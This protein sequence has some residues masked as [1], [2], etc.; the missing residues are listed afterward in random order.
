MFQYRGCAVLLVTAAASA[1]NAAETLLFPSVVRAAGLWAALALGAA[2]TLLYALFAVVYI[3]ETR[4]RSPED[5]YDAICPKSPDE[6]AGETQSSKPT[7]NDEDSVVI[8]GA[9]V[10]VQARHIKGGADDILVSKI[11]KS[12]LHAASHVNRNVEGRGDPES[13]EKINGETKNVTTEVP[14]E[15]PTSSSNNSDK[16]YGCDNSEKSID[17]PRTSVVPLETSSEPCAQENQCTNL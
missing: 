3:P 6:E 13:F 17:V 16:D 5:I 4:N 7:T 2:A 11:P 9:D 8:A 15:T 12:N 10:D 14:C 1:G